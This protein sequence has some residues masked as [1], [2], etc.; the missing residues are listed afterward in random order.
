VAPVTVAALAALDD[1]Q[2]RTVAGR[3]AKQG[4]P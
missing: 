3:L 4:L 1:S 2:G